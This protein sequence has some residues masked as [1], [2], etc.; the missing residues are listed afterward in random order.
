M[1][2]L[3]GRDET[4]RAAHDALCRGVEHITGQL[5]DRLG[6]ASADIK[7]RRRLPRILAGSKSRLAR[8]GLFRQLRDDHFEIR[9]RCGR[10]LEKIN[11][12][13]PGFRP[14]PPAVFELVD[15][16]LRGKQRAQ[17]KR[18]AADAPGEDGDF[19]VADEVLREQASQTLTHICT[20]LGL[21]L[22]PQSVKL[23][24]RALHTDDAKLRGVALEY[25]DS[26]LP[27]SVSRQL[28]AHLE[29][30][31]PEISKSD[32]PSEQALANLVE[33]TPT[34]MARLKDMGMTNPKKP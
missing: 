32:L 4:A 3:L 22:P 23:A 9:L 6:D 28:T 8:D 33:S 17:V 21:I 19:L 2:T 24:F 25:L 26:V 27:K 1:I 7:L 10:A 13:D 30:P 11:E 15:R 5:I 29:G 16:E 20:L 12:S 34:I 31:P 14:D 18:S